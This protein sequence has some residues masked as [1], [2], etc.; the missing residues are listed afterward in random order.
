M[1]P[2]SCDIAL[3]GEVGHRD[4]LGLA[5]LEAARVPKRWL[6]VCVRDLAASGAQCCPPG[7]P[8][9]CW[10]WQVAMATPLPGAGALSQ[11]H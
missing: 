4:G 3:P 6:L 7:Q 1:A 11:L 2:F 10:D 9:A 8:Q 5:F